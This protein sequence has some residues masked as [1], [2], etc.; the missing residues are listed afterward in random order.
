MPVPTHSVASAERLLSRLR[1]TVVFETDALFD[2]RDA[3]AADLLQLEEEAR[4]LDAAIGGR[5]FV[6]RVLDIGSW[7]IGVT[8]FLAGCG[9]YY[10][11]HELS[12]WGWS[13]LGLGVAGFVLAAMMYQRRIWELDD[14]GVELAEIR[15]I[16]TL[17]ASMIAEVDR[18]LTP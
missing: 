13:G 1:S 18:R 6:D 11:K 5:P 15:E 12:L 2:I 14:H 17:L 8:G 10:E 7:M 4:R 3:T 16:R 9:D